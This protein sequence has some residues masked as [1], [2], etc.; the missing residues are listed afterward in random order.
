V[1]KNNSARGLMQIYTG[2]GKGKTT[3]AIGQAVRAAGAGM[4]V[5]F[6]QF[7]KS[8][9]FPCFEEKSL[10]KIKNIKFVRFD[11]QSPFFN[12]ALDPVELEKQVK[13]DW[14]IVRKAVKSRKYGM[15][16]LDEV[17]HVIN[18]KLISE[19]EILRTFNFQHST[20]N[21][22]LT[23]R[24]ASKKLIDAADLVTEM[25]EIKHPFKNGIRARKGIDY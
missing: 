6:F 2:A 20:I 22:V 21:F 11:E 1:R 9:A 8:G 17:T 18:L 25:K 4:K 5:A 3:A 19:D 15:I 12:P 24:N 13:N 14:D 16:I 7:L 23:G 10:K